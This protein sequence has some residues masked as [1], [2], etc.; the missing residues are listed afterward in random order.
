MPVSTV[1]LKRAASGMLCR[2]AFWLAHL[3]SK[4]GA[5][6][7]FQEGGR[8]PSVFH[9]EGVIE[10]IGL[11]PDAEDIA[12]HVGEK[13]FQP[14]RPLRSGCARPS[15]RRLPNPGNN[16]WRRRHPRAIRSGRHRARRIF[17]RLSEKMPAMEFIIPGSLIRGKYPA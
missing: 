11:P 8:E 7:R 3:K 6:S 16:G 5:P 2:G 14:L 17:G 13:I 1:R 12:A 10:V 9:P 15:A 4:V